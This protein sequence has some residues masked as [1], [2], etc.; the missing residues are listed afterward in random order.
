MKE[1]DTIMDIMVNDR[2]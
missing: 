1:P 2:W